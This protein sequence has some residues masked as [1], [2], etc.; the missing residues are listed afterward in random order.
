MRKLIFE[1]DSPSG[2]VLINLPEI[3]IIKWLKYIANYSFNEVGIFE[4]MITDIE[5]NQ[6]N[7]DKILIVIIDNSNHGFTKRSY[8]GVYTEDELK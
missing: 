1:K 2:E 6:D 3:K 4:Q 7:Q 8:I 5:H